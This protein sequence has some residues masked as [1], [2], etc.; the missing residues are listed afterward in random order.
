MLRITKGEREMP[1]T[2]S[3]L[4]L[5]PDGLDDPLIFQEQA[6]ASSEWLLTLRHARIPLTDHSLLVLHG[7]PLVLRLGLHA[8][9]DRALAGEPVVYLDG[10]NTFDPFV[11]GRLARA[12]RQ[13]PRKILSLVHVARA[14]T[15]HQMERLVS[16]CL[17]EALVRYQ[18]RIAVVSG[19]FE[20][21]YDEAVPSQEVARL[22]S[23]MMQSLHRMAQRGYVLVSL[24]PPIPVG[25]P[26]R[27]R[28]I[29][30]LC[31]Q[32]D[33]VIRMCEVQGQGILRLEEESGGREAGQVWE[34]ARTVLESR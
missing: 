14:F 15:C 2:A 12:R 11:I 27:H 1:A 30:Q 33:R 18:A 5:F 25:M 28:F 29:D 8:A 23:R 13:T 22:A 20:T 17:E 7:H 6:D 26:A 19:L 24:C 9:A 32:A 31:G 3:S 10:A 21:F 34:V 16:D 4:L